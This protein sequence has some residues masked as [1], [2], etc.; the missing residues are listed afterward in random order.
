M[1]ALRTGAGVQ[2][3][4]YGMLTNLYRSAAL[5]AAVSVGSGYNNKRA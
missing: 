4:Y 5:S 2:E 1:G 3:L